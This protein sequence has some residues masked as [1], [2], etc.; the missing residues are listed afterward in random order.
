MEKLANQAVA[1][2][3]QAISPHELTL[4]WV[5]ASQLRT[6]TI[7]EGQASK[8]S[9]TFRI[10]R[11]R[12]RCDLVL[13]SPTVSGLHTEIYFNQQQQSFYLRNLRPT[14]PPVINGQSLTTGEVSLS[15]GSRL[16]LGQQELVVTKIVPQQQQYLQEYVPTPLPQPP[17]PIK[18]ASLSPVLTPNSTQ[19]SQQISPTPS[20]SRKWPLIIGGGV[21][22]VLALGI[23]AIL[24][25]PNFI[26]TI[27]NE[28]E[29]KNEPE[30]T[31]EVIP[32]P[33]P[34]ATPSVIPNTKILSQHLLK[35][36]QSNQQPR[37]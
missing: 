3:E 12:S 11:D 36:P 7:R 4:Q 1:L 30:I 37:Q 28:T 19:Q 13:S 26:G 8:N 16:Q 32:N 18:T 15:Q 21:I 22:C 25:N 24:A 20:S 5:E 34:D 31:P 33:T 29:V 10:G 35:S 2:T 23:G 14:N 6:K 27:L 17:Q 9:G